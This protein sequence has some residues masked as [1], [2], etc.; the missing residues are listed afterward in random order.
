MSSDSLVTLISN[1]GDEV[2][3]TLQAVQQSI[4]LKSMLEVLDDEQTTGL[5]IPLPEIKGETLRNVM[6]WCE[7]HRGET[8]NFVPDLSGR[9]R[10][11]WMPAWDVD[12]FTFE[13]DML[14]KVANAAN[15]LEIPR[16]LHYTAATIAFNLKGKSTEEMREYLHIKNDLTPE[17]EEKIRKDNAWVW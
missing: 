8:D 4:T 6:R 15:Y 5:P 13:K 2:K 1:D 11:E 16:L 14:F 3:A 9:P 17:Q 10:S 12:F 7:H